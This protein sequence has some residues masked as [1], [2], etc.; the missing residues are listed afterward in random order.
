MKQNL[1]WLISS[2]LLI[3]GSCSAKKATEEEN[4]RNAGVRQVA[5]VSNYPL[6]TAAYWTSPIMSRDD[7]M[8]LA[9]HDLLIVDLE[10]KFNNRQTLLELKKMNPSIKLLAYSNPMEIFLEMFNN[11][12]W[13]NWV[14]NEIT[15]NRRQWLLRTISRTEGLNQV[16]YGKFWKDMVILNMASTCPKINGETYSEWMAKKISTEILSDT[17]FDGYFMDNG[18][19]NI[20]WM[21]QG[22]P[23]Y[24]DITGDAQ[25]RSDAYV[26]RKW[27]EGVTDYLAHIKTNGNYEKGFLPWL[28]R[29]FKGYD[30]DF[31]VVTNK[32]DLNL[33]KIVDGKFF[34]K[35]PN[36]YIGEKWAGGWR[37]SMSNARKTGDY[38]IIN[39]EPH[40]LEFGLASYLLLNNGYISVG[41]DYAAQLP[42]FEINP[43]RALDVMRVEGAT[44]TREYEN[45]SVRVYPLQRKGEI[46]RKR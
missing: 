23:E 12:P 26:D 38:T 28:K 31:I 2:L 33:L 41:Q 11:R 5:Q 30:N 27:A 14:I 19:V 29:L 4:A 32:G 9:K 24:I 7:A 3:I 43:G 10:N 8:A 18:T 20:S 34:E 16:S 44:Y 21:Y 22:K 25:Y 6:K 42:L 39:V 35:F 36:D 45:I 40:E 15:Q 46:I 1:I 17:I 37:Q 13:Q